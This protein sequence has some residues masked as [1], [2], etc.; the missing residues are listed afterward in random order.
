MLDDLGAI[1]ERLQTRT[2]TDD[3]IQFLCRLLQHHISQGVSQSG[4]FNLAIGEGRE[5]QIGDR[6]EGVTP[7]QIRIIVQ[8]LS[9]L[10]AQPSSSS[11]GTLQ[12]SESV[13]VEPP[14]RKLVLAPSTL[15][16]INVRLAVIEEIYNAGYLSAVQQHEFRQ[17]KQ[18]LQT[19]SNLNQD[20]QSIA[21]QGDRLIQ[22]AV[23]A[24]R[25][26]VDALKLSGKT[27]TEKAHSDLSSAELECQQKETKIFQTFVNCLEDSRVGADWIDENMESLIKYASNKTLKQFPNLDPSE[28][29]FDD[30]K[31]S[32]KQFLEQVSF[33]LS[34]GSYSILDSPEIPLILEVEQYEIA[35][36]AMK[37]SISKRLNSETIHEIE[38]CFDYLID[39]LRFY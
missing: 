21:E 27:L 25:L 37:E 16:A 12:D 3:D 17:F 8:E 11:F 35:F 9:L 32:L 39:R 38:D 29:A 31:F 34:W 4:K 23:A 14:F 2:L 36:Q 10:Q 19:F 33:C 5:I 18:R 26:Q 7:E 24:M 15:E 28:K 1:I 20:L 22:E 30:F 6:Y 13:T